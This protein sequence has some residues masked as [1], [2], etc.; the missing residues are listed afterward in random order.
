MPS[1]TP[2]NHLWQWWQQARQSAP[3][4]G[5]DPAEADWLLRQVSNLSSLD[6]RLGSFRGRESVDLSYSLTDLARLW[7]RRLT[8]RV[9]VQ[10]LVGQTPWRD[11][12]LAVTPAVLIPRPETELMI[13]LAIAAVNRHPQAAQLRQGIWADLGTGSGAIAIALART[14]PAATII[15]TDVSQTALTVAERNAQ[16]NGVLVSACPQPGHLTFSLGS[17]CDPL[18]TLAQP[19]AGILSNPPY[20]PRGT[21]MTL[22]PEVQ[23]HEP[24]L[25]LDGGE[26]GLQ[27]LIHV[28]NCAPQVLQP[29]G[30]WLVEL[31]QGQATSIA[32]Y[33]D[34][35]GHYTEICCHADLAGI[36][37]FVSAQRA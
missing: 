21:L 22:D 10:Y 3:T 7:Q 4:A 1:S 18:K 5:V 16:G 35:T 15:A 8:D 33:L 34:Q 37:R 23:D 2:G 36:D 26:D 31:M 17:W 14:F 32:N 20:I 19:L 25:A 6:L 29:G 11:L 9:P 27:S 30:L 28:S 13:D 12:T 24:L